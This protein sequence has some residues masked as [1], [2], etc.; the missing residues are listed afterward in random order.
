M[1]PFAFALSAGVAIV[2]CSSSSAKAPGGG[3]ID[4]PWLASMQDCWATTLAAASSCLPPRTAAPAK[5]SADAK[6][7]TY[8][9]GAVIAFDDPLVF[10]IPDGKLWRFTLTTNGAQC[11]RLTQPADGSGYT[12]TTSAGTVTDS[13]S[14]T[15]QIGCPDGSQWVGKSVY[16]LFSCGSDGGAA[17]GGLPGV[18]AMMGTSN[19]NSVTFSIFG[20]QSGPMQVFSCG[21]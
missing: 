21:Q 17:S 19:P 8:Q 12:L 18:S 3:A 2:A 13:V 6:A 4:C 9:G 15:I 5:L 20:G 10:P 7:C 1:R 14:G 16:D 11:L